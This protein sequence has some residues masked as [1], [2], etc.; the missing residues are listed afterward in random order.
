MHARQTKKTEENGKINQDSYWYRLE[1]EHRDVFR[2]LFMQYATRQGQLV[3]ELDAIEQGL[4]I[5]EAGR[6]QCLVARNRF[7][8]CTEQLLND[9][10][11]AVHH[12]ACMQELKALLNTWF[13]YWLKRREHSPIY[14]VWNVALLR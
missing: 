2:Q 6:A 10:H 1:R 4:P 9:P 5:D 3:R 11:S 8:D 12:D 13:P 14:G 7:L